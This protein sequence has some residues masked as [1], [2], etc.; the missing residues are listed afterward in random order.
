MAEGSVPNQET[1]VKTDPVPIFRCDIC[2]ATYARPGDLNRHLKKHTRPYEC[3]EC[4]SR[5]GLRSDLDRHRRALHRSIVT[6]RTYSCSM[7]GCTRSYIRKDHLIRHMK[8]HRKETTHDKLLDE[9][10]DHAPHESATSSNTHSDSSG[11]LWAVPFPRNPSF[12]GHQEILDKL[13]HCLETNDVHRFALSGLGGIGK[14]QIA[15]EFAHQ[16]KDRR[17]VFWVPTFNVDALQQAYTMIA[18]EL[19]IPDSEKEEHDIKRLVQYRLSQEASGPWLLIL[20]NADDMDM[21]FGNDG[22]RRDS[23]TLIDYMPKSSKGTI[24]LTTRNMKVAVKF[25]GT[26]IFPVKAM[27][28]TSATQLLDRSLINTLEEINILEDENRKEQIIQQLGSLP[29]ALVQAAAYINENDIRLSEY[30]SLL[31]DKEAVIELLSEDFEDERR[32]RG[33]KN[34]VATTWLVSFDQIRDLSPLAVDY[35]AFISCIDPDAIPISLLPPVGSRKKE[36]D[37]IGILTAYSFVERNSH[38]DHLSVHRLVQLA[39]QNWLRNQ[40]L[41]AFWIPKVISRLNEIMTIDE[42][43]SFESWRRYFPH[44]RHVIVLAGLRQSAEINIQFLE[45]YGLFLLADEDFKEAERTFEVLIQEANI[46]LGPDHHI[47]LDSISNL[48]SAYRGQGR[49]AEALALDIKVINTMKTVLGM[50]HPSTLNAMSNLVSIYQNQGRF[51]EAE[52]LEVEALET[53]QKI[54]G[55]DH[56]F[57]LTKMSN[58]AVIW[59]KQGKLTDAE[60][61][62]MQAL[63]TRQKVLGLMHPS[64]MTSMNNLATIYQEQG[65][66]AEAEELQSQVVERAES[67]LGHQHSLTLM[68]MS[69]LAFIYQEQGRFDEAEHL[70][71][72]VLQARKITLGSE[73]P[74]LLVNMD[75]LAF[76]YKKMGRFEEAGKLVEEILETSRKVLGPDHPYTSASSGNLALIYR[77]LGRLK[78]AEALTYEID[79]YTKTPRDAAWIRL[80]GAMVV[81]DK[82]QNELFA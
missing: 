45:K 34:A 72:R 35:M 31:N 55:S 79:S 9:G 43:G 11:L 36:L 8:S 15:L 59:K 1:V 47:T 3:D 70:A 21:W 78:E 67:T 77:S 23:Q 54:F 46:Q 75:N 69:D 71:M 51:A 80:E 61:L 33:T 32:Y 50:E 10:H 39:M 49:L 40:K 65:L 2:Q 14:T 66:L 62:E 25:A 16:I 24:L 53:S 13:H 60:K 17:S 26:H 56:R 27:D 57:T 7:L 22:Q 37:T 63:K 42:Y 74:S 41:L 52:V 19:Q 4:G 12:V 44:A 81:E 5:F 58:L 29:L 30:L 68:S 18:H 20:D 64:T 73:H 48:A 6:N 28:D 82:I 76:I 38:G